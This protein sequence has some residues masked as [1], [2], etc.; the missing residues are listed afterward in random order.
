MQIV[1]TLKHIFIVDCVLAIHSEAKIFLNAACAEYFEEN[2]LYK[3]TI[4]RK[5]KIS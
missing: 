2:F 3:Q 4:R 1:G 5:F